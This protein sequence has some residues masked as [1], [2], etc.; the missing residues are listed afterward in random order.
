MDVFAAM[1]RVVTGSGAG[2]RRGVWIVLLSL[3]L[4]AASVARGQDAMPGGVIVYSAIDAFTSRTTVRLI[5]PDGV[6]DQLVPVDLASPRFPAISRD[7]RYIAA[8]AD[9]SG[10]GSNVFVFTAGG[11][12]LQQVTEFA[13]LHDGAGN[14]IETFVPFYKGFSPDGSELAVI[15]FSRTS[16]PSFDVTLEIAGVEHAED[17]RVVGSTPAMRFGGVDWSPTEDVLATPIAVDLDE[18]SQTL[19]EAIVLIDAVPDAFDKGRLR[20]LTVPKAKKDKDSGA[21]LTQ[22]D[23]GPVFSPDGNEVAFVRWSW[24]VPTDEPAGPTTSAIQIVKTNGNNL[25]EVVT[26]PAGEIISRVGWSPDGTHLVFDKGPEFE[27]EDGPTRS[28]DIQETSL[29]V[30]DTEGQGLRELREAPAFS[31]AWAA[32]AAICTPESDCDDGNRCTAG[33]CSDGLCVQDRAVG[34]DGADCELGEMLATPLCEDAEIPAKL[35]QGIVKKLEQVRALIAKAEPRGKKGK[36]LLKRARGRLANGR[37][38]ALKAARKKKIEAACGEQIGQRIDALRDL[39]D[40]LLQT[41][42]ASPAEE[43]QP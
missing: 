6:D 31:P 8:T 34:F 25:R 38:K 36:G 27:D 19:L 33:R 30:V 32:A 39:L 7:G 4:A 24:L 43:K 9:A 20:L 37:K 3:L 41:V 11:G 29:W 35:Q 13:N 42:N 26:F 21:V 12:G 16:R 1:M 28:S 5:R 17:S 2:H 15:T 10:R 23:V 18:A 40:D 22:H 14:A